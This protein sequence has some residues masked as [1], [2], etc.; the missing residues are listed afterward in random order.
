M[1]QA[2]FLARNA[3]KTRSKLDLIEPIKL[4]QSRE[5]SDLIA[6]GGML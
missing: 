6:S 3:A 1:E 5:N 2:H 4:R